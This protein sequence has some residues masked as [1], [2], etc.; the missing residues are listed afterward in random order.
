MSTHT[1]AAPQSLW[2]PVGWGVV[3]AALSVLSP[4]AFWWLDVAT[5]HALAIALIA[6]IYIGFA[7][8][9]GRP[10]VIAV[11]V[12]VASVF[13]VLAAFGSTYSVW[14]LVVGYAG[15]GLKDLW[16]G[17]HQFVAN[18]RWWPPFCATIDL[19]VAAIL[20]IQIVVGMDF[21]QA[22][23]AAVPATVSSAVTIGEHPPTPDMVALDQFIQQELDAASIPGSAVVVTRG[24]QVLHVRGFGHDSTNQPVT[25]DTLFRIASLSKSFTS[26][27]VLQLAD[28]GLLDLD[29]PVAAHLPEFR[30]ADQRGA[31]IT[32]RQLL[33]Q[34]SGLADREVPELSRPQPETL[35]AATTSLGSAHLV[36][37]PGTQFNYHNPNYQVA[38]RLVEVVGGEPFAAY[39]QRHIFAPARM[40]SSSTT[41][42][43]DEPVAGLA[44][45]YVVAFGIPF[46]TAAPHIFG[47]GAGDVVSTAADMGRWLIINANGGRTADG[48]SLISQEGLRQMHTARAPSGYAL[49]WE[50]NGPAGRPERI[51]HSGTLLTFSAQQAVL[52]DSGFGVAMLFNSSS[53]LLLEQTAIFEG[54]LDIIQ[55]VDR[56]A[57][58]PGVSTA[59]LDRILALL[60][61]S[62]LLLGIHAVLVARHWAAKHA[63]SPIRMAVRFLPLVA[64]VG[65][66]VLLPTI[67][68][69]AIGGRDVTWVAAFYGWPALVVFV[70]MSAIASVGTL[71]ARGRHLG[72]IDG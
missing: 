63:G 24:D 67:L 22:S 54:V 18:T 3:F 61:I 70:A 48:T 47:A 29:D 62:V 13:V 50:T 2:Q 39:L 30:P 36:A 20:V 8:A 46:A 42:F 25:G 28:A 15:H 40:T 53:P 26:L 52:P 66:A 35:E 9:D 31:D 72:A 34:T 56:P 14:L 33:D 49:G 19:L 5:V 6:A 69:L 60:S 65:A 11:E 59:T 4:L 58:R 21:H 55:G 44:E 12:A 10:R 32:V 23:A 51:H 57:V 38:A 71:L 27:A 16:Q 7:V 1:T 64:V 37:A 45:G 68:T 41:L 17:R 43:D